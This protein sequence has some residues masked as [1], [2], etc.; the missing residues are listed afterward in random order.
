VQWLVLA[1]DAHRTQ[2]SFM[3]TYDPSSAT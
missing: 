3:F 2:G 1:I